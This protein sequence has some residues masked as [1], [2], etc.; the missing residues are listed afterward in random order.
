MNWL[1]LILIGAGA[2]MLIS[3]S[4]GLHRFPN[5]L[6]R[7]HA[8]GKVGGMATTSLLLALLSL[9]FSFAMALKVIL[10]IVLTHFTAAQAAQVIARSTKSRSKSLVLEHKEN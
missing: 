2:L 7:L 9:H 3:A 4:L 10:I 6:S 8:T 5:P 1:T